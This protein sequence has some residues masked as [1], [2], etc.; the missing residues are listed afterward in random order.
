MIFAYHG[1]PWL[2]H[3][4][5]YRRTN[6]HN[7][8]VRGYKEEGTTTTPFDMVMLNDMDR[9]HLVI[10]VIDRVP[11][12]GP[13]AAHLRQQMVDERLR[14][15]AYT[16]ERRRRLARRAR[17][18]L[19]ALTADRACASSSSTR[20][21]AASS[22]ACSAPA[23]SS[24]PSATCAPDDGEALEAALAELPAP[25]AVGH[26]VVHGGARFREAVRVDDDVVAALGELTD[27]AP[28]HQPAALAGMA[29][30]G[31]ALP[32]VPAV[33]CF[34]TA[35]HATLPAAAAHLRAAAGVARA[36]RPAALRLPRPLARVRLAAAPRRA[37]VVSCHLGAG[38]SLAAVRD[39]VC[40]DT[41]MG[42]TPMEGLVMATRAGSVDPGLVLW[43]LRHGLD[44][45]ALE[46]GLDRE[47]GV[48][49]LAGDADMRARRS[50]ATT[51]TPGWRSTSTSTACAAQIAAMAA[52]LGGLDALVFT[53]GVGEHAPEIRARAAAGL[54]FLGVELDA[55]ANARA[56]ADAEIGAPGAPARALVVT[57]RED[58]EVARQVR[59]RARGARRNRRKP[60]ALGGGRH[61][62]VRRRAT[63]MIA[64]C[65]GGLRSPMNIARARPLAVRDH[66][67]VPLH[68][69]PGHDRPGDLHG[70]LPDALVP[71]RRRSTGC[72]R[73]ASGA[74]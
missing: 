25:D 10:D 8:H 71:H 72:A 50:R 47:G 58:L 67:A 22:S 30:V 64:R 46:R 9:F 15:R 34:D 1:Y 65:R 73:R 13:R 18:D 4:L 7:L 21:P 61:D 33:A 20:A 44:V 29:A 12:L 41:T 19:A 45:D 43:L 68:L 28:L 24:R 36:L 2:I 42:F 17:L 23:T 40:V 55:E 52:A 69:R 38:A 16:R 6:H 57:A 27:L 62:G 66:D 3:R 14:H 5:T 11:G 59:E 51:T 74:S 32:D 48:R 56:T 63:A 49:G 53:G 60:H 37:R 70:L 31:R 35:F 39:G 54:G 26:R